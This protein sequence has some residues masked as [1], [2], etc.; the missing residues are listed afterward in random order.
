MKFLVLFAAVA[1]MSAGVAL[2]ADPAKVMMLP[3]K[4]GDVTFEHQKHMQMKDVC[5]PCHASGVGG[6]IEGFGKEMAHLICK[7]CHVDQ[8]AGPTGCKDCHHK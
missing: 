3:A 5:T 6:K 1:V 8:K 2:A 7:G 4:P